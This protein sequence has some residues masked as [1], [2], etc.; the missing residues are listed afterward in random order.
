MPG[1]ELV[2]DDGGLILAAIV[3]D[4][5]LASVGERQ[6]RLPRLPHE[7]RQVL[8]LVLRGDEHA[9]LGRDGLGSEAHSRLRM[10]AGR[11]PSWS[12]YFATVRRAIRTPRWAN[13]STI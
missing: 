9:H 8:R 12:R 11:T 5:H 7:L 1:S 2:Q 3:H 6:Q 4:D 10:R 13:S